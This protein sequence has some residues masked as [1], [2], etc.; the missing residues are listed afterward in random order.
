[1]ETKHKVPGIIQGTNIRPKF[2][3]KSN[4]LP[5]KMQWKD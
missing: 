2:K 3:K 1:M 5:T 4:G